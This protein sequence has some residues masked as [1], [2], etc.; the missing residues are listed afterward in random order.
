MDALEPDIRHRWFLFRSWHRGTQEVDLIFGSFAETFLTGFDT[1]QLDQFEA[2][3]DC[4]DADLL[5]W[6]T[7]RSTPPPEYNHDVMHLLR[8]SQYGNT[9]G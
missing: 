9:K 8:S 5:D 3:L 4:A 2:L 6:I 7:G 1:A